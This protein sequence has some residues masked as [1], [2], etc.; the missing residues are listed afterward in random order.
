[1]LMPAPRVDASS[2]L[3]LFGSFIWTSPFA[4]MFSVNAPLSG[5]TIFAPCTNPATR[6]PFLKALVTLLPTFSTTP[7]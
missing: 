3:T 1:M 2:K 5:L 4:M 6:S 7:A